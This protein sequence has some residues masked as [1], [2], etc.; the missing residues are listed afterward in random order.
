MPDDLDSVM[1]A[2]QTFRFRAVWCHTLK[3][4]RMVVRPLIA[5][6][7]NRFHVSAAEIADQDNHQSIVIGV[8]A[9]VPNAAFADS[10]F[11]SISTF[12][13]ANT[14]AELVGEQRE[15]R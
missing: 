2:V 10:L 11:E 12:V 1:V 15:T 5:K 3:E 14:E 7:Q 13:E 4:K 8:A 6:L 9:L